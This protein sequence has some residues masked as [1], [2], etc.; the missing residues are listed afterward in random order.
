VGRVVVAA[1]LSLGLWLL[2]AV[3]AG[4]SMAPFRTVIGP[5]A[6]AVPGLQ[7]TG[8]PGGCDVYILNQ[9]GQDVLL[10]DEGSPALAMR[11]PSVPKSATPPPAAL[12]HLIGK[13]KCSV[14]PGITEDQQWNQVPVTVLSWTL[15]GNVGAQQF[16]AP[17]Q[18]VYD[19][20]LDPNAAFLGYVRIGATALALG[21]LVIGLPYLL[22]RRRQILSE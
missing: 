15:R 14:L 10:G 19:P 22:M 2:A 20:E 17:V 4:A 5:V 8:A 12:V 13:W 16:K 11:F 7:L 21:G 18:T 9:T 6:P 3:G 1:W